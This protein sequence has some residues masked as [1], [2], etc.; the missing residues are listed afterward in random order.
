MNKLEIPIYE[1]RLPEYNVKIEPDCESIGDRIDEL[2]KKHFFGQRLAIRAIGSQEHPGKTKKELIDI[3]LKIGT[4]RYDS[5]RKGDRYENVQNKKIDLFALDGL[6]GKKFK[7][8]GQLIE[9]FYKYPIESGENPIR[10]DILILYDLKKLKR[11]VHRYS[12]RK[13]IKRDGFIFIYPKDK[14]GAIKGII[15]VI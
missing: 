4:D 14:I 2:I 10:I 11:V 7:V 13:D 5:K 1:I 3:I 12:G 6:V 8:S 9:S 15:K